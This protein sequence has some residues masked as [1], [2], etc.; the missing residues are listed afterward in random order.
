LKVDPRGI[1]LQYR[2]EPNVGEERVPTFC[3]PHCLSKTLGQVSHQHGKSV[4]NKKDLVALEMLHIHLECWPVSINYEPPPAAAQVG[5]AGSNTTY[6]NSIPTSEPYYSQVRN[7][8]QHE[9]ARNTM[10]AAP[11]RERLLRLKD[12]A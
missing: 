3:P 11:G 12:C 2:T 8:S 4:S 9:A 7:H 1:L 10:S 5:E 6:E